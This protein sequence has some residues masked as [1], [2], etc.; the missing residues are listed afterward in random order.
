MS[1]V[2]QATLFAQALV[3]ETL[4]GATFSACRR[5]RYRLWEIWDRTKPIVLYIMLNPSTADEV[6]NDPTVERC[7]RRAELLGCGGFRIA[8]IFAWRST[9]PKALYDT[10]IDPISEP[11]VVVGGVTLSVKNMMND[12]FIRTQALGANLVI[13]GWG[14]HGAHMGRGDGVMAMLRNANVKPHA[15]RLNKSGQPAH[16]LYIPYSAQPFEVPN[17]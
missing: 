10:A 2:S 13:C 3:G 7:S 5:Y 12:Q 8:N 16:P 15:L 6:K 11:P 9:D 17:A 4:R 1:D 14:E